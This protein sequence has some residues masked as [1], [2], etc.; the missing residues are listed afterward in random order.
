MTLSD[1]EFS[2]RHQSFMQIINM[3]HPKSDGDDDFCLSNNGKNKYRKEDIL[4]SNLIRSLNRS[5]GA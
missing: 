4:K 1:V 5:Q 3:L 2:L